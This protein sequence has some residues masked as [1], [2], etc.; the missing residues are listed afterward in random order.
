VASKLRTLA[1]VAVALGVA[2]GVLWLQW[3][4]DMAR[5]KEGREIVEGFHAPASSRVLADVVASRH[6]GSA[7]RWSART[8]SGC[9][10]QV[11]V[12][13]EPEAAPGTASHPQS[14]ARYEFVVDVNT[15]QIA[16]GNELGRA[17]IQALAPSASASR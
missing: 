15:H 7:L 3:R 11:R 8:E 17:A 2:T 9:L 16:P 13:C 6:S 4:S 14:S 5:A 1:G 10:D 12:A